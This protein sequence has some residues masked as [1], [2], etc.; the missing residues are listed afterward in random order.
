[1]VVCKRRANPAL[2]EGFRAI[3]LIE[4]DLG[5]FVAA[6]HL[7]QHASSVDQSTELDIDSETRGEAPFHRGEVCDSSSIQQAIA[8][9]HGE[10]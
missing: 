2:R 6:R 4:S 9:V 5:E 3:A 1:M 7:N 8:V 10:L